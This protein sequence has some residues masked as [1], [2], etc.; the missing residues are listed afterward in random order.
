MK[1]VS[2]H[3]DGS[4]HR[5]WTRV[6]TTPEP[7]TFAIE[8]GELVREA[9]GLT[10]SSDYPVVA[11]FWPHQPYQVFLLMKSTGPEYYCN[12]ITPPVCRSRNGNEAS[13]ETSSVE[14][15]DLD[16]DVYVSNHE[17][18][19]EIK[20]LDREEFERRKGAYCEEWI[21]LA[22]AGNAELVRMATNQ[23]GPFSPATVSRWREYMREGLA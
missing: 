20:Q 22:E 8:A 16:L 12:V 9:S 10:W 19:M 5:E 13:Y 4:P 17:N 23:E 3:A 1:L 18:C 7:W 15:F 11:F 6:R 14:F 2:Y 21:S